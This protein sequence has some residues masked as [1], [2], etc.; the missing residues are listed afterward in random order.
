MSSQEWTTLIAALAL[1]I[2]LGQWLQN[3][4]LDRYKD[5]GLPYR[6]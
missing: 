1:L 5:L 2:A 3:Q 6:P 4:T